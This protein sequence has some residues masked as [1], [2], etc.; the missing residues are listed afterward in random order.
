LRLFHREN[1]AEFVHRGITPT[2]RSEG[3]MNRENNESNE[4]TRAKCLTRRA[5]RQPRSRSLLFGGRVICLPRIIDE[6]GRNARAFARAEAERKKRKRGATRYGTKVDARRSEMRL[7]T[8]MYGNV[9]LAALSRLPTR[10]ERE[11]TA[12]E[13]NPAIM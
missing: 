12:L 6:S 10:S 2:S 7:R 8:R 13:E 5:R 11:R 4:R 1:L 3:A 9:G